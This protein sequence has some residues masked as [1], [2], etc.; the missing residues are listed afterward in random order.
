[1]KASIIIL[2][3]FLSAELGFSQSRI[4]DIPT[5]GLGEYYYKKHNKRISGLGIINLQYKSDSINFRFWTDKN[6]LDFK[7]SRKGRLHCDLF[8]F[9]RLISSKGQQTRYHYNKFGLKKEDATFL[10]QNLNTLGIVNMPDESKIPG[11]REYIIVDG[12]SCITELSTDSIYKF[13]TF[14]SPEAHPDSFIEAKKVADF[15]MVAEK[16]LGL[17]SRF[18]KL[19]INKHKDCFYMLV[20]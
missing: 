19:I 17:K 13:S 9:V 12:Y 5:N 2:L 14:S 16:R 1:M 8:T 7:I 15:L 3:F 10:W 18:K 4:F 6:L 11:K 20:E